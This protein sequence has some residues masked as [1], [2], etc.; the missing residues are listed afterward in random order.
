MLWILLFIPYVLGYNTL[1][2]VLS[3]DQRFT[4]LVQHLQFT[5]LIPMLNNLESGTFFAPDN[6]AFAK[7]H[8]PITRELLLYHLVDFPCPTST[9][10]HGQLVKSEYEHQRIKLTKKM[11]LLHYANDAKLIEK[12]IPVNKNT[13]LHM[14]NKVL[15]TPKSL[16]DVMHNVDKKTFDLMNQT[17]LDINQKPMT[18][19]VSKRY[20]LDRF[21]RL[22]QNYLI[23][24]Y[25]IQDLKK[26]LKYNMIPQ[27][28][29]FDNM[30]IGQRKYITE[31][32]E[33]LKIGL[34]DCQEITVNGLR[35]LERDLITANG[36]IHVLEDIPY[37]NSFVFDTRKYLIGM[38]STGYVSMMDQYNLSSLLTSGNI[39]VLV[40]S[41]DSINGD[42]IPNN[43]KKDWLKYHLLNGAWSSQELYNNQ[44]LSTLLFSSQ[45]KNLSQLLDVHFD[46]GIQFGQSK[47]VGNEMTMNGNKIY[48]I[49]QPLT[50]PRDILSTLI[51]DLD[52][53]SFLAALSITHVLDDIQSTSGI[54]LF[55]PTNEAFE[56]LGLLRRYL[57][58]PLGHQDLA[59][60]LK[61]HTVLT[62]LYRQDL[63]GKFRVPTLAGPW[64]TIQGNSQKIKLGQGLVNPANQLVAN[65]VVHRTNTLHI[66]HINPLE[67]MRAINA[68]CM[69]SLLELTNTVL[70]PDWLVLVP[71]NRAF[72]NLEETDPD[73]LRLLVE[74]HI[75][76]LTKSPV[77]KQRTLSSY[78]VLFEQDQ[79]IHKVKILGQDSHAHILDS[80]GGLIEIDTVLLPDEPLKEIKEESHWFLWMLIWLFL[81]GFFGS[82]FYIWFLMY[83]K[84]SDYE[85]IQ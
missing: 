65:G 76:P 49:T 85:P 44:L 34:N 58:H 36:V 83:S 68:T 45:L 66:P 69:I 79:E 10:R 72:E 24:R 41:D 37:S 25:G 53:S 20:L 56:S 74:L 22:E 50:L 4:T 54:T 19:F 27:P 39:T 40:P 16:G 61:Q 62:L 84:R 57:F 17:K 63:L 12:D 23:S 78:R 14:I 33:I 67:L 21:S 70:D 43:Q 82:G 81:V 71:T 42:A 31:S 48:R 28:V 15:E 7:H 51:T 5:K 8:G 9:M 2:D 59:L 32:G 1:I 18:F 29:Y 47:M 77:G 35:V 64:V 3:K 6:I 75:L 52:L 60:A 55:V 38:N 11:Q 13:L 73:R 26:M 46:Q 30:G 80:G